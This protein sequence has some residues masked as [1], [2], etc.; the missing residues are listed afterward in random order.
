[1]PNK[2]LSECVKAQKQS[3][4]KEQQMQDAVDAYHHE[5]TQELHEQKG[6]R[7]IAQEHGIGKEWRT[8]INRY[9]GGRSGRE[10]H[11]EQ[12]KLTPAEEV[13][14]VEFVRES[15]NRGFPMTLRNIEQYANLV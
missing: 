7:K 13:I 1:M 6:A 11:E 8:I 15:A 14:I 4:L 12:Q 2:A 10:A 5:Q 9:N 3:Q